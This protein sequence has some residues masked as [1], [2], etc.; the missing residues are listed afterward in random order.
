MFKPHNMGL[1]IGGP[2][3]G[4]WEPL[5]GRDHFI[6]VDPSDIDLAVKSYK[7]SE[8]AAISNIRRVA[9]NLFP[10]ILDGGDEWWYFWLVNSEI[11]KFMGVFGDTGV[12]KCEYVISKLAQAYT[13]ERR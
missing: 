9:Y 5:K 12:R 8:P 6:A 1:C 7:K 13:K 10:M 11:D 4:I 3:D 2:M